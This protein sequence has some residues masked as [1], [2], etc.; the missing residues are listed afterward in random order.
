MSDLDDLERELGPTLRA[1]LQRAAAHITAVWSRYRSR[2]LTLAPWRTSSSA[3]PT[4]PV[5]A[6]SISG[7]CPSSLATLASAPAS[8]RNATA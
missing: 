7:V 2:A 4:L 1:S 3:T 5:R 6:A 8:S